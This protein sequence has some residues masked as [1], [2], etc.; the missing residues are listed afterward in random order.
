MNKYGWGPWGSVVNIR[1]AR[2][3]NAP[4]SVTTTNSSTSITV[5]WTVPFN[6]GLTITEYRIEIKRKSGAGYGTT[7]E[8]DG[9]NAVIFSDRSCNI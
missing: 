9:K 6:G 2:P 4:P 3:P 8:C 5:S 1:C 7:T